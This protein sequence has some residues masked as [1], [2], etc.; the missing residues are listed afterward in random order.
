RSPATGGRAR[1]GP[2]RPRAGRSRPGPCP[3]L[4]PGRRTRA[5]RRST[6]FDLRA[7]EVIEEPLS[8]LRPRRQNRP[9]REVCPSRK[10]VDH[11]VR[12]EEVELTARH[13]A[14]GVEATAVLAHR[15]ELARE[16]IAE[17]ELIG[18]G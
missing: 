17:S 13:L 16:R 12:P 5:A 15:A 4:R 9:D 3:R 6:L 14:L 10:D 11:R 18:V 2:S 7:E 1:S 8:S